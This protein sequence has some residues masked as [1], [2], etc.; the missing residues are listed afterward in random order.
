MSAFNQTEPEPTTPKNDETL[1]G[2]FL[3]I[4]H[5]ADQRH[6][7]YLRTLSTYIDEDREKFNKQLEFVEYDPATN[8]R[9]IIYSPFEPKFEGT[10]LISVN[11][12]LYSLSEIATILCF[13]TKYNEN[14]NLLTDEKNKIPWGAT[15]PGP[16]KIAIKLAKNDNINGIGIT[17]FNPD[18]RDYQFTVSFIN[19]S[20]YIVSQILNKTPASRTHLKQFFILNNE[21]QSINRITIELKENTTDLDN[22]FSLL[23]I[24]IFN[25]VNKPLLR[26][27]EENNLI[28]Y[29]E[30]DNPVYLRE[31]PKEDTS[32]NPLTTTNNI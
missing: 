30:I 12:F 20:N 28:E 10:G 19:E 8:Q 2:N 4:G 27:M 23:N 22:V 7:Q 16:T 29:T 25:T 14:I 17:F 21:V 5:I 11:T 18:N 31:P 9:V 24:S 1:G 32:G 3:D 13:D 15:T 6:K 26:S